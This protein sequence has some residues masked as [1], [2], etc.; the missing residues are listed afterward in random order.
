M[1]VAVTVDLEFQT[2]KYANPANLAN[3]KIDQYTL[4]SIANVIGGWRPTP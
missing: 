1:L 3:G 4:I 2:A